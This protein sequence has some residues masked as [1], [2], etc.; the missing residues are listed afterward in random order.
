MEPTGCKENRAHSDAAIAKTLGFSGLRSRLMIS[1]GRG[2]MR[3]Y[4]GALHSY[5]MAYR[6]SIDVFC[7]G[8][9]K[10]AKLRLR[11]RPF[12]GLPLQ[13]DHYSWLNYEK[14]LPSSLRI[15]I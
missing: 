6:R 3:T 15:D 2:A 11:I 9:L 7:L 12:A 8:L 5:L 4:E 14:R 10:M 1:A 13:S